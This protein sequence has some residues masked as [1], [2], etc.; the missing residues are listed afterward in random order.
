MTRIDA[1]DGFVHDPAPL[2][3]AAFTSIAAGRMAGLPVCNP[4]LDVS[5]IGFRPWRDEWLGALLTPWSLSV[6][7]LPGAGGVFRPLRVGESQWWSFPSG[8]YEF[9]GNCEPG[10]GPYQMCSLYSPV[11][12]FGT[13]Y[14]AEAVALAAL[15][16]LLL[17]PETATEVALEAEQARLQG[18]SLA[19]A[20]VSRRAF[21]RGGLLLRGRG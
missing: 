13:Q 6:M 1:V 10:V 12:E 17:A 7:L 19:A 8:N 16:A 9:L 2:V 21:L 20:P 15:E 3:E 4:A 11:F 14:D 18:E 5:A